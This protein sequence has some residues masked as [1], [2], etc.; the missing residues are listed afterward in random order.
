MYYYRDMALGT[1]NARMIRENLL[2]NCSVYF[3]DG[4]AACGYLYP[5]KVTVFSSRP[6]CEVPNRPKGVWIGERFDE[7][8]NDQDW[9]LYYAMQYLPQSRAFAENQTAK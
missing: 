5:K 2:G 3:S 8:A 7:Y 4:F 9:A 1:D 6:D